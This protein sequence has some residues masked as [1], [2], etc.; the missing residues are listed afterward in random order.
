MLA[1]LM[2]A[3][4][5]A[6]AT[7]ATTSAKTAHV[8]I[9]DTPSSYRFSPKNISVAAGG[10]VNWTWSGTQHNVTFKHVPKGASKHSSGDTTHGNFTRSFSKAGTYKYECTIHDFSG[11]VSAN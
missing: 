10:K 4:V 8:K 3:A 2:A 1:L 11:T 6:L 5:I 9:K 7:A